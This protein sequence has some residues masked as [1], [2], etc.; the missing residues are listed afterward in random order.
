MQGMNIK[1]LNTNILQFMNSNFVLYAQ[2]GLLIRDAVQKILGEKPVAVP[3]PVTLCPPQ[4]T[5]RLD[6]NRTQACSCNRTTSTTR[7]S[8]WRDSLRFYRH[9]ICRRQYSHPVPRFRMNGARIL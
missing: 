4:T 2:R 1:I 8:Q 9:R 6:R 7:L 5:H 3:V